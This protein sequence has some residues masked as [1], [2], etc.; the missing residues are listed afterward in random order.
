[1]EALSLFQIFAWAVIKIPILKHPPKIMQTILNH[2]FGSMNEPVPDNCMSTSSPGSN[3]QLWEKGAT[4]EWTKDE[5]N[6]LT[7]F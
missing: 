2:K 3:C 5:V 7:M 6:F 4:P 1:M